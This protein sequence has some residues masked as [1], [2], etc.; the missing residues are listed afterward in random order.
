[1]RDEL[2]SQVGLF[3][4]SRRKLVYA[5]IYPRIAPWLQIKI[6]G[7]GQG[8]GRLDRSMSINLFL[9]SLNLADIN[10]LYQ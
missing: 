4:A 2:R 9:N 5:Y 10:G 6:K 1:M 7:G 3:E 8:M